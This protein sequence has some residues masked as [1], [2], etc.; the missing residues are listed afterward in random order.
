MTAHLSLTGTEYATLEAVFER[1]FPADG[2]AAGAR[3]IGAARYVDLGLTGALRDDLGDYRSGLDALDR[4]ARD[5]FGVAFA[6]AAAP[7]QDEL[8]SSLQRG[9]LPGSFPVPQIAFFELLRMHCLEGLFADPLYGGNREKLGWQVLGHPGVWLENSPEE[10]LRESPADKNGVVQS[11]AD[12]LPE[13]TARTANGQNDLLTEY[14]ASLH[15]PVD[16]AD[17]VIVGM[18]GVGAVVAPRLIA[19]GLRVVGLE[20]GPVWRDQDFVPDELGVAYYCRASMGEKFGKENPRWRADA[21]SPT[22]EATYSLGRM[23]NGVGGSVIHYGA[24]LRRFHPHHLRFRSHILERW[25]EEA[26]P[27]GCSVADW[28]V[29]YDELEPWFT[30]AEQMARVAG[31]ESNPF[32]SRS[33]PLPLPPTRPFRLGNDF[34]NATRARGLH[35]HPAPVGQ[36]TKATS[37]GPEMSYCA[38]NNGFGAWDGDKWHPGKEIARLA[39]TAD[40]FTLRTHARV[41]RVLIDADGHAAGVEYLDRSGRVVTQRA[42]HVIL[43]AYTYENIRLMLLSGDGKHPDGLGNNTGQLGRHYMTKQF[44]HVDGYFPDRI[45]NRHTGPASQAVVLDDYVAESFDS[46][47]AGAFIGGGTLGAENQ[48]LPLQIA[49]ESLPPDVPSWGLE[50]RR[51]LLEWQRLGVVRIQPDALP[52]VFHTIDLDPVHRE[53]SGLGLPVVRLT[54]GLQ[55]N[56][57]KQAAWFESESAAIL[58]EMGAVTTWAGP[59]FTGVCSSHDLGGCRSSDDPGAGVVDRELQVHDTPGLYVYSGAAFPTCPGINPTLT[60]WALTLWAAEQLAERLVTA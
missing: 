11:L 48:F 15:E 51:H 36:T 6:E 26:I 10:H 14:D 4:A 16:D 24:W 47:A 31:D 3:E 52:Y 13:L 42:R 28:P 45:F 56:E 32:I 33:A 39:R 40:N 38:W 55:E 43:A 37:Y 59:N 49:R 18:G 30:L 54:Y 19:A 21:D 12:V 9:V 22:R 57:L 29:G 1:L 25:G 34:T 2:D 23:M 41:V 46:L 35:P 5:R 50:Y 7:E 44:A 8:L 53:R 17:V 60:I 58:R 20:A 27:E